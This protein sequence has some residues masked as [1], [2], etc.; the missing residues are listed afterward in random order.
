MTLASLAA[1]LGGVALCGL[2]GWG[3]SELLPPLRRL[4]GFER[5]GFAYLLGAALVGFSLF[6]ASH[7]VAIHL[8]RVL[9]A[10]VAVTLSAPGLTLQLLR[11][12]RRPQ[13][14]ES[15]ALAS[16]NRHRRAWRWGIGLAVSAVLLGPL[17]VSVTWPLDDWDGRVTWSAQAAYIRDAG[18]VDAEVLRDGHWFVVLPRYPPLLPI[19]QAAVQEVFGAGQDEQ[20][21]RAVYVGFWAAMLAVLC[22]GCRKASGSLASSLTVLAVAATYFVRFGA[23]GATTAY[24]DI[25]LGGF[26][27]AA[28][29]LLLEARV[30]IASGFAAGCLLGGAVLSK[31]EGQLLALVALLLAAGRLLKRRQDPARAKARLLWL[32]A[33][34]A[35]AIAC[36]ALLA[37]WRLGIPSRDDVDY[38]RQL[39]LGALA[40]GLQAR[41]HGIF[42][43]ASHVAFDWRDWHGFWIVYLVALAVAWRI[44][45]RP[46]PRNLLLGGIAP[47]AVACAGYAVG[48]RFLELVFE[49]WD[50]ALI[51]GLIPLAVVLSSAL[52]ALR[53]DLHPRI[54]EARSV[55]RNPHSAREAASEAAEPAGT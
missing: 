51:Q 35:P 6:A 45:A 29:L 34:A 12:A 26:Y 42:A 39:D 52:A 53:K 3:V 32:L 31:N 1:N 27:G 47:A 25:A 21:Y 2:P 11:H 44:F 33:A 20:F 46:L 40:H 55:H 43:M 48:D 8:G 24:S 15:D 16:P 41:A 7:L 30:S 54:P 36:T 49:T 14:E 4:R 9:I 28:L 10:L 5:A 19:L 23:G 50:R 17:A 38:F 22:W 18:T 37:S 13:T